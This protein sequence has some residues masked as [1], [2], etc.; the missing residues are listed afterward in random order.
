MDD[1]LKAHFDVLFGSLK[2]YQQGLFDGAFKAS[3]LLILVI[4][5]LLTSKEARAYLAG[6]ARARRL[7]AAALGVGSMVYAAV[8][9]RVFLLSQGVF[10]DLAALNYLPISA[11]ADHQLQRSTLLI[12]VAQNVLLTLVACY[13]ILGTAPGRRATST[14]A[15]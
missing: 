11:Y 5:W 4:G 2:D 6:N 12:L 15:T 3:G 9:W 10:N 14:A 1:R 13:F 8:S 7:C